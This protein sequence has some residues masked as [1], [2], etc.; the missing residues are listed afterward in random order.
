MITARQLRNRR[1]TNRITI[2]EV[3]EPVGCSYSWIRAIESGY[4]VKR[5]WLEKYR[6][7]LDALV[8]ERKE[9][10]R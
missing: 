3:A 6:T 7:A 2:G 9:A 4:G 8:E 1:V 10:R 5:E